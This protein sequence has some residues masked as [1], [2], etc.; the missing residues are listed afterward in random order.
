M[1]FEKPTY[2][3][4]VE[5]NDIIRTR[6]QGK[7]GNTGEETVNKGG[8]WPKRRN[9]RNRLDRRLFGSGGEG[10]RR[11]ESRTRPVLAFSR[12]VTVSRP[13]GRHGGGRFGRTTS[14]P[15]GLSLSLSLFISPCLE[16]R[17]RTSLRKRF[18]P[19][20]PPDFTG[21]YPGFPLRFS[22]VSRLYR[23]SCPDGAAIQASGPYD[24]LRFEYRSWKLFSL[25]LS[26][27]ISLSL[28]R[29]S[30]LIEIIVFNIAIFF[31]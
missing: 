16:S 8:G 4:L 23:N 11:V 26:I 6:E 7:E 29:R 28:S 31:F 17:V 12:L 9:N 19:V 22:L 10:Q 27:S 1:I 30:N 5:E 14:P 18:F 20:S 3:S 2:D 15:Y 13:M 25:Y 21:S 24:S